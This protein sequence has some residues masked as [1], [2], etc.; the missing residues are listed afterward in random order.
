MSGS[1]QYSV[2][3]PVYYI[4]QP[5]AESRPTLSA[6][7]PC[8]Q[9]YVVLYITPNGTIIMIS[10]LR[11]FNT[12]VMC[13]KEQSFSLGFKGVI[14]PNGL[15]LCANCGLLVMFNL[16]SQTDASKMNSKIPTITTW[17]SIVT[18]HLAFFPGKRSHILISNLSHGHWVL[19]CS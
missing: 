7:L 10:E 13:S 18:E 5:V 11:G 15:V 2:P 17:S 14:V 12:P 6:L 3:T 1:I 16:T 19:R 4:A 8:Q 9:S